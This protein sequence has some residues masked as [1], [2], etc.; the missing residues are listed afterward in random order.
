M[1]K[2]G[3]LKHKD[4][5]FHIEPR[6]SYKHLGTQVFDTW[7]EA[8]GHAVQLGLMGDADPIIDVVVFSEAGAKWLAGDEGVE[9]YREDPE[10]SVFERIEIR[11][12][13]K[14]RVP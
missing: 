4:V 12:A 5:E 13:S 10:A 2:V 8:C 6:G 3:G 9:Q 7:D 1:A 14:G 11:V